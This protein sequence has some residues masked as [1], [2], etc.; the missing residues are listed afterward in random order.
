MASISPPISNT[1]VI[2]ESRLGE[3]GQRWGFWEICWRRSGEAPMRSQFSPS[4]VT[5]T[6]AWVAGRT[7]GSP[8]RA[9]LHWRHPQFHCG[10]PPPAADP[11]TRATGLGCQFCLV[12]RT[13]CSDAGGEVPVDFHAEADFTEC[14]A[15]PCHGSSPIF[16]FREIK[17]TGGDSHQHED[18]S[19][20][21]AVGKVVCR[22]LSGEIAR[23]A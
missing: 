4:P 16:F 23:A 21:S 22:R 15:G 20:S 6:L 8:V 7:R 10:K 2:G 12:N 14:R 13:A 5:A 9:R 18:V 3:R 17:D 11:S 19:A 1:L